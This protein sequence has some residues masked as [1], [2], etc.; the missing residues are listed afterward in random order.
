MLFLGPSVSPRPSTSQESGSD[1]PNEEAVRIAAKCLEN[2]PKYPAYIFNELKRGF[3]SVNI[4]KY[5]RRRQSCSEENLVRYFSDS[6]LILAHNFG[7]RDSCHRAKK[8]DLKKSFSTDD[9]SLL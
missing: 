8:M 1:S 4:L 2:V 7:G 5:P 3:R 9:L 6:Q